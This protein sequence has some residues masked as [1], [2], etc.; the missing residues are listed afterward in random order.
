M[1]YFVVAGAASDSVLEG[2]SVADPVYV[3]SV[4]R[5]EGTVIVA[6]VAAPS[7]GLSVTMDPTV[8]LW[9]G[10]PKES[11]LSVAIQS[12]TMVE[13][14]FTITV[15]ATSGNLSTSVTINVKGLTDHNAIVVNG[16]AGF[17]TANGVT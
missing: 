12:T 3:S 11:T 4:G 14:S 16:H 10:E 15:T 7:S 13:Q 9:V 5:F 2:Q 8:T 6:A 17:T 1:R